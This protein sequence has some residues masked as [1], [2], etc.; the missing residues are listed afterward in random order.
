[1]LKLSTVSFQTKSNKKTNG[2]TR[3]IDYQSLD[4]FI[5]NSSFDTQYKYQS[6][7]FLDA[8]HDKKHPDIRFLKPV[9]S[10]QLPFVNLQR[11]VCFEKLFNVQQG[12]KNE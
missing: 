5:H 9:P 3:N 10:K 4:D 6:P 7:H 8:S 12:I 2:N 11:K 1:M